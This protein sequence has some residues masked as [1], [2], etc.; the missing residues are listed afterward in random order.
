MT[1][2]L[3]IRVTVLDSWDE[4][5]LEV[6]GSTPI[7]EIKRSVLARAGIRRPASEYL[8]KFQGA[9]LDEGSR[10]LADAGVGPNAALIVLRRR[11]SAVR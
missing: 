5:T 6:D 7:A 8:V 11:R 10:T 4:A 3:R 9:E 1:P 2:P